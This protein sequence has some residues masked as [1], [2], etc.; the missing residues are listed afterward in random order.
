MNRV[1][2]TGAGTINALGH[3]VPSTMEAMREGRCGIGPL[4]IRDVERLSVNIG[5]QV[6]NYDEH[7]HFNRQ[8]ISL[9]DRFTQF[10]LLAAGQAIE[11]SGLNFTVNSRRGPALFWE[12]PVGVSRPKTKTIARFMK[13]KRTAFTRSSCQN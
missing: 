1:V 2:I 6:Q 5:G 9:Y 7:S 13:R 4:S 8:Q 12:R 3:D 11:Q 10:A